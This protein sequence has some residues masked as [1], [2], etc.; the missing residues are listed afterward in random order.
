M[1][2]KAEEQLNVQEMLSGQADH[3]TGTRLGQDLTV[4]DTQDRKS[5][6]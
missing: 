2:V 6:V 5:V 1:T 3:R 4:V